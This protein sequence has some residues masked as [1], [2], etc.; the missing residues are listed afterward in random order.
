MVLDRH[1]VVAA[2]VPVVPLIDSA[3]DMMSQQIANR[4][5]KLVRRIDRELPDLMADRRACRQILL[6][7]L[8]NPAI[9]QAY[10]GT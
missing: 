7:L 2:P 9:V 10:L 3:L 6:N 1:P 5:V 8:S 4:G